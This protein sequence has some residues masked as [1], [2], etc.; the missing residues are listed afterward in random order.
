MQKEVIAN[1][2]AEQAAQLANVA[3]LRAVAAALN[4]L[5]DA[6]AP[7]YPSEKAEAEQAAPVVEKE[8][9]QAPTVVETPAP[10]KAKKAAKK[11]A[12]QPKPEPP[13][14]TSEPVE[15]VAEQAEPVAEQVEPEP[16]YATDRRALF[17][18]IKARCMR[19]AH[20]G[21]AARQ[22]V[23]GAIASVGFGRLTEIPLEDKA[24]DALLAKIIEVEAEHA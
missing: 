6:L 13:E 2:E 16:A 1:P 19:L 18:D 4:A 7:V 14:L 22:A 11:V 9:E 17:E 15:P 21:E 20:S 3:A 5:A 8:A 23:R 12:E 24:L 10:I